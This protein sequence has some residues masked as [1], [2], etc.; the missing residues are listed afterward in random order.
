MALHLSTLYAKAH[1]KSRHQ[2]TDLVRREVA[3][4]R[5]AGATRPAG[6]DSS[7]VRP[8]HAGAPATACT[9]GRRRRHDPGRT[10]RGAGGG[11]ARV[12]ELRTTSRARP[13]AR[14]RR[15]GRLARRARAGCSAQRVRRRRHQ[16]RGGRRGRSGPGEREPDLDHARRPDA[17]GS[18]PCERPRARG[19]SRRCH[20]QPQRATPVVPQRAGASA[21]TAV[22]GRCGGS[23]ENARRAWSSRPTPQARWPAPCG[24]RA[25]CRRWTCASWSASPTESS[26][27]TSRSPRPCSPSNARAPPQ[28]IPRRRAAREAGRGTAEARGQRPPGPPV[29]LAGSRRRVTRWVTVTSRARPIVAAA[30]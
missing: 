5:L 18:A 25:G 13:G 26:C 27:L 23:G 19:S 1:V 12:A 28:Q 20:A 16:V 15:P 3:R 7:S 30:T 2:F 24:C 6:P 22:L 11:G 21:S 4:L 9:T 14:W 10:P 8:G 29:G 17:R